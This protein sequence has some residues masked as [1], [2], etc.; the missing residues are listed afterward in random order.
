MKTLL[1][2]VL[3]T[4]GLVVRALMVCIYDCLANWKNLLIMYL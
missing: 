2:Y 4:V 3:V 1:V